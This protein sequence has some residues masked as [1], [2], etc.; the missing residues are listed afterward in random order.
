M[1]P[2]ARV[3]HSLPGRK[4]VKID[5]K[6]GDEAYFIALQKELADCPDILTVESN[7]LTGTVLVRHRMDDADFL[8]CPLE[9][10]LFRVDQN[11]PAE[12]PLTPAVQVSAHPKATKRETNL[13]STNGLNTR[14]LVFLG[15]MGMGLVQ[16]IE[17]NIA[18]P[19]IAAFWYAFSILPGANVDNPER[20][21]QNGV[22]EES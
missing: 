14:F 3:T 4:R 8:R 15:M 10:G 16:A 13:R 21:S 6:R 9:R 12:N 20:P 2:L 5:E 22:L 19:A 7:P 11:P 1:V 18:I 17:G